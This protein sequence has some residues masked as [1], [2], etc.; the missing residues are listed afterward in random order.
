MENN[1]TVKWTTDKVIDFVNWFLKLKRIPNRYELENMEVVDSFLRGDKAEDWHK[2]FDIDAQ[3]FENMDDITRKLFIDFLNN[4]IIRY[5]AAH[6][7]TELEKV[8][9]HIGIE[10]TEEK[11]W[12][13]IS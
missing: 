1:K 4:R 3:G 5:G 10:F 7:S 9:K 13:K 11:G 6:Q 8:I 2:E 12:H